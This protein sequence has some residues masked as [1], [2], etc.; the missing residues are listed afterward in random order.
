MSARWFVLDRRDDLD[1]SRMGEGYQATLALA[2]DVVDHPHDNRAARA[3]LL[4]DCA[5]VAA[6]L[7]AIARDEG[8]PRFIRDA[9]AAL[10]L[11]SVR[12]EL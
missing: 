10:V 9:I 11:D 7:T 1:M 4:L 3:L 2:R 12:R 6:E 8:D 5:E